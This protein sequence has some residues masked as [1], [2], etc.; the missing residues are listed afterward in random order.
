MTTYYLISEWQLY[1][2]YAGV[3][4]ACIGLVFSGLVLIGLGRSGI[5]SGI[6]LDQWLGTCLIKG[7]MADETISAWAHRGHHYRTERLINWL[8][9]DPDH[10]AKA[11]ISEMNGAQNAGEYHLAQGFK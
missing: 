3:P 1:A 7:H 6:A 5:Q 8:F 4:F 2:I 11:Y 10:C 9:R